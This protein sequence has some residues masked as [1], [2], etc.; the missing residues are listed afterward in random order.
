M[1]NE[2]T[3]KL[4]CSKKEIIKILEDQNFKKGREYVLNDKYYIPHNINTNKLSIREILHTAIL[5]R[6]IEESYPD[7]SRK[8]STRIT[9]K[10]KEFSENGDIINQEKFECEI[11]NTDD[12]RKLIEAMGYKKIMDIKENGTIFTNGRFDI[13]VKDIINGDKLIEVELIE[14]NKRFDT[15]N[16][17]K[18][19]INKLNLPIDT[20]NYFVKKAEIELAKVLK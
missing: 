19:E 6:E 7:M 8:K 1:S 3:V 5:I 12:G 16:K 10:K 18:N 20:S 4:K 2:I 13:Q 9:F 14:D 15:I 11:M 17:L